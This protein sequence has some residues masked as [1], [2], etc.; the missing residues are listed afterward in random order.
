MCPVSCPSK[1]KD[2]ELVIYLIF[3]YTARADNQNA[4]SRS[5]SLAHYH[6]SSEDLKFSIIQDFEETWYK[7]QV[8][9][10][11]TFH[12]LEWHLSLNLPPRLPC[13]PDLVW[14]F[15]FCVF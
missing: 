7:N 11:G 8:F 6:A 12:M 3:L 1:K 2:F 9:C 14:L 4:K 15:F 10:S 13:P 5:N